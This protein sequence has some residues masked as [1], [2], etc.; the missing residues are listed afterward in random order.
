[1]KRRDTLALAAPLTAEGQ[2]EVENDCQRWTAKLRP[3][4]HF[5][6]D[7]AFKGAR[8]ELVAEDFAY[9]L[10]RFADPAVKSPFWAPVEDLRF[11][12]LAELRKQALAIKQPFK[13]DEPI[14]GLRHCHRDAA[15]AGGRV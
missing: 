12:G 15:A 11:V 2:R 9:S 1:M 4:I 10:K 5:S 7:P 8:R 3:G 6:D 14:P 13:C